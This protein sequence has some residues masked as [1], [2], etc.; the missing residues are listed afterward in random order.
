MNISNG[1]TFNR[2]GE[3]KTIWNFVEDQAA[4]LVSQLKLNQDVPLR[5]LGKDACYHMVKTLIRATELLE[6][7]G[8]SL[9]TDEFKYQPTLLAQKEGNPI[10][11]SA[12]TTM[13]HLTELPESI[14]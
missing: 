5:T 7:E 3:E 8:L 14:A 9:Y 4:I 13:A 1:K 12:L 2:F 11:A 10:K 6:K